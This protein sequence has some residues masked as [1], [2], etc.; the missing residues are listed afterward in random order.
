MKQLCTNLMDNKKGAR[1]V[2]CVQTLV[3]A[4]ELLEYLIGLEAA[5]VWRAP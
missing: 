5:F 3:S 2:P 4:S 1:L